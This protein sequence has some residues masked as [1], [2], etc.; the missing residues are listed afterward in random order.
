[1]TLRPGDP[2]TF[3]NAACTF[4]ILG[5]KAE[6]LETFRKAFVAGYTILNWAA[7]DFDLDCLYDDPEFQKLFGL[8]ERASLQRAFCTPICRSTVAICSRLCLLLA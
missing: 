1:V 5:K 2:N 8:T 3:Y 4:G 7:K 6:G